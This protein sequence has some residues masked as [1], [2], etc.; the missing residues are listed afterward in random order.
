MIAAQPDAGHEIVDVGQMVIDFT[1]AERDPSPARHTAEQLEKPAIARTVDTGRPKNDGL[2]P[3]PLRSLTHETLAFELGRDWLK[4]VFN[5]DM[6]D[7]QY[8]VVD[9]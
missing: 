3:G 9:A 1:P 4:G 8:D 7:A 5:T 6:V 2:D